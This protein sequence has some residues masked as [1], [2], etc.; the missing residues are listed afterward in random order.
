MSTEETTL[1]NDKPETNQIN[2]KPESNHNSDTP[3]TTQAKD[4]P[5]SGRSMLKWL[6]G[7]LK[8]FGL[9]R[10][11]IKS[12]IAFEI[13]FRILTFLVL[14]PIL[15]WAQRLWLV[16]NNTRIIAWYNAGSFAK[17]PITWIV[18]LG[19][20]L[21]LAGAALFEQFAI[22][23]MLHASNF[24]IRRTTREIFS[25]GFDM[26]VERI[27][28][29]NWGLIPF[30]Y[31]VLHFGT[32]M[33]IS[34]VTSVIRIPGFILEDFSKHMW[35][36]VTYN[37]LQ[38]VA[39][40]FFLRWIFAIPIMM[41]EDNTSF[42]K[43]C[44]KSGQMTKGWTMAKILLLTIF[45]IVVT[46]IIYF[47]GTGLILGVIYLLS[48]WVVPMETE[49]F[50]VFLDTM[51]DPVSVIVYILFFWVASPLMMATYQSAYYKRKQELGEKIREYTDPPHYFHRYPIIKWAIVAVCLVSIFFSVP[52]RFAQIRWM[53]NTDYGK[54]MIMAHRGFSAA[55]P[56]NTLPAFKACIDEDIQAAELDVQMLKDGTIIVLHDS[57]FKRTTGYDKDT[58]EVT[59]DEIKNLDNG[60]FFSEEYA[61]TKIP[62]LDEVIKLAKSGNDKLFLNIEI[63][64]TGHDD[65]IVQKVIDIIDE[66]DY[67]ANCDITSQ[68][69]STLEEVRELNPGVL[70]AYTSVIGIGDIEM[71]TA[72]DIISINETFA[73]YENIERIHRAG[74]RVFVWTVNESDTMEKLVSLNVD[75]ILTND[76]LVCSATLELYGNDAMNVIRRIQSAFSFL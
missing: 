71:L 76:P 50:L 28:L 56:E 31:F 22:Y 20:V 57:N 61:G 68:D 43:A 72:A 14:Y 10:E 40:Y 62:T 37:A 2:D 65:G 1:N 11:N 17:N 5:E 24:G 16:A 53:L 18:L 73:T 3:E 54:P 75:A 69:Y 8:P 29:E 12:L 44:R 58:W 59:Y 27:K 48:M 47:V 46:N 15:T 38:F 41:E 52:R 63:K 36:Q 6:R 34:S 7:V 49:P 9:L 74:K 51:F 64:R 19:M 35:E 23:D 25:G 39:L 4:K 45:W 13:L 42:G 30:V 70:T 60:S 67:F 55:A 66:N 26:C 33:D 21:L 32:I